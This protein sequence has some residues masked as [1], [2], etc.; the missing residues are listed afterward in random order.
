VALEVV[1]RVALF[2]R[3]CPVDRRELLPV[4]LDTKSR[5]LI[6]SD[7]SGQ[8]DGLS[9]DVVRGHEV[10]AQP[11]VLEGLKDF[12]DAGVVLVCRRH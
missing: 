8:G 6:V 2:V 1:E 3:R 12:D 10:V 4:Q 7:L 9:N 5:S 11:D